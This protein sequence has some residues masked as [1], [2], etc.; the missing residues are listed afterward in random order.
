M[1]LKLLNSLKLSD[2][3]KTLTLEKPIAADATYKMTM[4][5]KR[6][7]D[8]TVYFFSDVISTFV[9]LIIFGW[10]EFN[11]KNVVST[12]SDFQNSV[13]VQPLTLLY[14]IALFIFLF[15]SFDKYRDIYRISRLDM[16][17]KTFA[18]SFFA[19]LIFVLSRIQFES[20]HYFFWMTCNMVLTLFLIH[21]LI[22]GS[23]RM[24]L[25]T[26]ASHRLKNKIIT[27]NTLMIGSDQRALELFE[28]ITNRKEALGYN[29]LGFIHS[30]GKSTSVLD[31]KLPSL[32]RLTDI[33]NVM[34]QNNIEEVIIAIETSEHNKLI[35]ILDVLFDFGNNILIKVIPDMY[36]I[37]LGTV[38]MNHLYG[39]VLIEI[40]REILPIWQEGI[41]RLADIFMSLLCLI[42]FFPLYALIALRV[43]LSSSGSIFYKQERVGINGVPFLIYKFRSMYIDSENLGP[44]LSRIGDDRITPWGSIMRKWRLDELPQFWN[45][46]KG[47]MS[48]VGP[49]PERQYFIDQIMA[50]SPHYKHLLKVR[51]GITS[52]GQVK[53]GYASNV[54]EM[55]HRL[56]FDILYIENRSLALDIKILFYTLLVLMQGRGK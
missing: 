17:L 33:E 19:T 23:M 27:Y 53:Y 36:D 49:R 44:Q 55:I 15:A 7:F 2:N 20:Q 9:S 8:T 12:S 47:E 4:R 32:G 11:I 43:R 45:V 25:L 30:N 31:Q 42:I 41:K 3:V 18:I 39:A 35:S 51:P 46:I 54:D 29:F 16:I 40:K 26:R 56:R 28:E 22:I 14:G 48:I 50:R 21:F 38:K 1:L 6:Y 52:W 5:Q 24:F 10:Y 37:M 13:L 34:R